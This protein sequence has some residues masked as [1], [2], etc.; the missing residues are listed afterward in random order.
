MTEEDPGPDDRCSC[1]VGTVAQAYGLDGIDE[2]LGERWRG[3]ESVRDLAAWFNREILRAALERAGTVP[4]DG[5]VDNLY[6]VLTD[7][8]VGAGSRRRAR[9][10]LRDD[11]VSVED[12]EDQFISHQT[13]YRH[14]VNCLDVNHDSEPEG[15]DDRIR[16]WRDR[17][18]SLRNR[19]AQVTGRGLDQL[20]TA[21]AVEIGSPDVLVDISVFCEDCGEFYDIESFLE[22]REC[23]CEQ[24]TATD[25]TEYH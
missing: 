25:G 22:E 20:S 12:V 2:R 10:R 1:K 4:I 8:D 19:T 9:Q 14:L 13:L 21:D 18:R 15:A 16:V 23:D 7:D 24:P 17:I 5:E 6:R 11:D 3:D